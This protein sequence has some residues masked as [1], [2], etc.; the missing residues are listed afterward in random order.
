[1]VEIVQTDG[2]YSYSSANDWLVVFQQ[3]APRLQQPFGPNNGQHEV[4]EI[5]SD[6]FDKTNF[7]CHLP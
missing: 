1:M 2:N 3:I 4:I 5:Q 7:K 6:K